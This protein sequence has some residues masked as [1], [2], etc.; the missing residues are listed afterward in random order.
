MIVEENREYFRMVSYQGLC[1]FLHFRS[2]N[3]LSPLF[4]VKYK[5]QI[6]NF[7][8]STPFKP[9]GDQK[10]AIATL[11]AGL[12]NSIKHQVLH[13]VTGSGKTFT[14]ASVIERVNRPTL[15]ISHN[16][17]LAWQ[18]YQE[19]SEFF[20]NNA[21]HYFVS[22]YDYYQPEA[23]I[24]QSDI[25]ISKDA[26]VNEHIDKMR[27]AA[28]Q[29][30]L[31]RQDVLI[32]ASVSCI[33]NLGSPETYQKVALTI[34]EGQS[35]SRKDLLRALVSLGFSRNDFD[36]HY[37]NI[38]VKGNRVEIFPSTG[39]EHIVVTLG[40][41]TIE[42]ITNN[43]KK[44][45]EV[46]LF[47]ANFW[48][49]PQDRMKIALSNIR[50]ELA[51]R[52]LELKKEGK[53]IEAY[54]LGQKTNY[55]L[56]LMETVGYC[57]GIENYS[58]HLEFR[59]PGAPPFTLLNYF[60]ENFLTVVDES[61]MTIP[62]VRG[63]YHGDRARKTALI[64]HGF[65]LPSALDNRPLA[66]NEF[67]K[68]RGQT[69]YMS[70]TPA[71][72]ELERTGAERVVE[73]LVRPTGLLDPPVE[74][75]GTKNQMYN[76]IAELKR[77]QE[78]GQRALVVTITKRLAEDIAE[79]LRDEGLKVS[80]IHS[81]VKTLER[82]LIMHKLRTGEFDAVVGVNLLREGLDLPEVAL[83][84]IF[85]A[86]KEGFLRNE[87]TLLQTIGRA[88]R[89]KEGRAI[90]YAD[91]ITASMKRALK[92]TERRRKH[93]EEYNKAHSIVP[94][95]IHKKLF[96]MPQ[97]LRSPT[98]REKREVLADL[99]ERELERE[100][101]KAARNLDFERAAHLRDELDRFSSE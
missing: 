89:H 74:V 59:E 46:R 2:L 62:Q 86:D 20:P 5:T 43:D 79:Y 49:T 84:V 100:M 61:H 78:R 81:D 67:N 29:A 54:R 55:D 80:Y 8:L 9:R 57:S 63:M 25:Y 14:A 42:E 34:Q 93:Q 37:G 70:A 53:D 27:H 18:L 51:E 26:D 15:V 33:Y 77:V 71:E 31:T 21:V 45:S 17:T 82:P 7:T 16:K 50:A 98:I 56:E 22:Y 13:G 10:K 23:Y 95:S 30:L 38:R 75:R 94:T 91:T 69:I 44:M 64:E 1:S 65:R 72:Y 6:M 85:D 87:T 40:A 66:F 90:L 32:V 88:A 58:R 96:D 28:V 11:V 83:V 4:L 73:Q 68:L 3:G 99:S 36:P 41:D 35:I 76:A 48:T 19:F 101:K 39:D 24:P 52:V 97:D 60:P 12:E 47:P 92:E